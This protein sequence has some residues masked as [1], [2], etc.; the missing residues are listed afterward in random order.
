MS[1]DKFVLSVG[2]AHELELAMNRHGGDWSKQLFHELCHGGV[3]ETG[4]YLLQIREFLSGNAT[5]QLVDEIVRTSDLSGVQ[6]P[7]GLHCSIEYNET[8]SF[9]QYH[10]FQ[11]VEYWVHES[12][13]SSSSPS[14]TGVYQYLKDNQMLDRCLHLKDAV[15]IQKKGK[16]FFLKHFQ[17]KSLYFWG[18]IAEDKDGMLFV[19]C[20]GESDYDALE[21]KIFWERIDQEEMWDCCLTPRVT[22]RASGH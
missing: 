3:V 19:P 1:N 6:P 17:G 4:S 13:A 2:Q 5:I 9:P 16:T 15:A 14:A 12:Q 10:L 20:L 11:E 7:E 18:S 8:I 21:P 22:C